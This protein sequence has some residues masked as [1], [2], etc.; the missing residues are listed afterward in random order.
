METFVLVV[1]AVLVFLAGFFLGKRLPTRDAIA[2]NL[3][4]DA[5]TER[6]RLA[7]AWQL[8]FEAATLAAEPVVPSSV[9]HREAGSPVG[10]EAEAV[11]DPAGAQPLAPGAAS[12]PDPVNATA[13]MRTAAP[14]CVPRCRWTRG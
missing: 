12:G 13:P 8:G 4:A 10:P 9:P 5:S 1:L 6:K 14:D 2:R 3:T 11:P 7:E